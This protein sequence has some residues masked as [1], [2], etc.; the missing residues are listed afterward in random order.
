MR[1]VIIIGTISLAG[2]A[3]VRAQP[4]DPEPAAPEAGSGSAVVAPPPQPVAKKPPAEPLDPYTPAAPEKPAPPPKPRPDHPIDMPQ[5]INAPTGW[6]LPAAVLYSRTGLDTGGGV[7]SDNRVGLGDVAEFGVATTDQIRSRLNDAD[8]NPQRIQPYFTASF[9]LGLGEGRL[10]ENQPG[11]SLGFRKSFENT[12][13]GFKTQ[14][15][16][17]TLVAS[18]K[19][20]SR[21]AFHLGGAFWDASIEPADGSAPAETLHGHSVGNQIRAFGGIQVEPIERSQIMVDLA[22]APEF[23]YGMGG[24]CTDAIKLKPELSWGVRYRVADWMTL[25][26]GVKVPD[27]GNANLLNAQ[28]FGMVTFTSW[29]LRHTVDDLK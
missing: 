3:V 25:E 17:L 29:G 18:K 23:C 27:I 19:I 12:T 6:I 8:N 21:S 22:W 13:D 28:I 15:A 9:R 11:I 16:E 2:L 4:P 10:F 20:G 5:L 14:V 24:T 26:S 1:S 7:T